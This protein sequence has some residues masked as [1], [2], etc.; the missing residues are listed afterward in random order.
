LALSVCRLVQAVPQ[1]SGAAAVAQ[2]QLPLAQVCAAGQALAQLPQ[3]IPSV[4]RSEH[5][6]LQL[7]CPA[8][9]LFAQAYAPPSGR[10]H[11]DV[12]PEQWTPQ[13]PQL[14]ID[15]SAVPQPIPASAQS[16]KP[17]SQAYEQR[18]P[19]QARPALLTF[20]SWAQSLVQEPQ[21]WMSAGDPHPASP[22][23]PASAS[24][25]SLSA[26]VASSTVASGAEPSGVPA[27]ASSVVESISTDE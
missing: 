11:R 26:G 27:P 22:A 6:P 16:A 1:R 2:W 20:K 13:A 4:V 3:C 14:D 18:P 9:Q 25:P 24:P 5:V 21:L 10:A 8:G 23:S 12:A 19:L 17:G 7:V 15:V